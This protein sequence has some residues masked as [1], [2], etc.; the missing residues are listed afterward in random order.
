LKNGG[1]KKPSVRGVIKRQSSNR[2]KILLAR[3]EMIR[4]KG[5]CSRN[6]RVLGKS[7]ETREIIS[8]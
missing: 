7:T 3:K 6:E 2:V 4:E 5:A 8:H 1:G